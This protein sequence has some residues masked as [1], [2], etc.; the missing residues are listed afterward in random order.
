MAFL[1]TR[2][3]RQVDVALL[4]VRLA[5]GAVFIAHGGQ[6]LFT[7]GL[8]GVAGSFGQMGIPM[9]SVVGPLVAFVEFFGGIAVVI[10]LL[11][12]LASLGLAATML[13]AIAFV[14]LPAG[15]FL[16]RGYEFNLALLGLALALV[17][18]GAGA[19]SLDAL[20]SRRRGLDR[21]ATDAARRE[22]QRIRVA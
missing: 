9:A 6:K 8:S 3:A 7:Y 13:G 21:H 5:L 17:S 22:E 14:H 10:G 11:T 12:R 18:A 4:F 19:F 2:T 1:G 15:F 20:V 16:P